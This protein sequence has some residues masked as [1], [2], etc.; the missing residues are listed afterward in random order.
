MY[1]FLKVNP[2]LVLMKILI[3]IITFLTLSLSWVSLTSA[4]FFDS[5]IDSWAPS[6][7]YCDTE[8]ECG[9]DRG[10]DIIRDGLNDMETERTAS[11]YVQDVVLYLL[12]F[13]TLV[14]VIYI[15]YA[16]VQILTWNGDEE[17]LKKSK[18]IIIYVAIGLAVIWLAW[19]I[20]RFIY[21]VLIN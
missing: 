17:K 11:Q 19:P 10:I 4:G 16:G 14:A 12:T 9:L 5:I 6:I 20:T 15:I 13:V 1:N 21:A 7:R 2:N 3:V 18:Q 8:G